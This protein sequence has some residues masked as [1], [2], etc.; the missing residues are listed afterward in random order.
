VNV[1]LILLF[2]FIILKLFS[3]IHHLSTSKRAKIVID[4]RI[5]WSL[6]LSL[7]RNAD[8]F[9]RCLF[10]ERLSSHILHSCVCREVIE[11]W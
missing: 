5:Y 3:Q 9:F 10:C 11:Q 7:F 1:I 4:T 8:W 2:F 6:L